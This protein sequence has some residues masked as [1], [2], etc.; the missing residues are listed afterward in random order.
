MSSQKVRKL[1]N[2]T[3]MESGTDGIN[4]QLFLTL[5]LG[6]RTSSF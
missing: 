5:M 2:I 6:H 3:L 1:L 4:T